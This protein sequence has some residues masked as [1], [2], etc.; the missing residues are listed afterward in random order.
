MIEERLQDISALDSAGVA[1]EIAAS[2]KK[3]RHKYNSFVKWDSI[4]LTQRRITEIA[5]CLG[6]RQLSLILRNY[7]KDYKYWNHGM[8]D[9]ILWQ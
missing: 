6:G 9:L 4:K 2:Y 3:N 8:P 5:C 7:C 1:E